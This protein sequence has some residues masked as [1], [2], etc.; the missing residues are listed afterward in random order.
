MALDRPFSC[1]DA[2]GGLLQSEAIQLIDGLIAKKIDPPVDELGDF[3][4]IVEG[5]FF[6]TQKMFGIGSRPMS[7][8]G[9]SGPGP[10]RDMAFS[11]LSAGDDEIEGDVFKF[12]P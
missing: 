1:G 7:H 5:I 4:E 3:P 9:T 10:G 6:G 11:L 2:A 8:D 12:V